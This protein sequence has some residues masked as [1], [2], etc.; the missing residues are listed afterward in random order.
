MPFTLLFDLDGTLLDTDPLHFQAYLG[1]LEAHAR[2]AIDFALYQTRIMGFGHAEI[3]AMLFPDCD[4]AR[5]AALADEKEQRFRTLLSDVPVDPRPGLVELL[6]WAGAHRIPCAV[7][8]NAPRENAMQI[9]DDPTYPESH[10][11]NAAGALY[12]LIPAKDKVL[13]PAGEWNKVRVLVRGNH[14]EHNPDT[15]G[16]QCAADE[17]RRFYP[18]NQRPAFATQ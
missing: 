18:R 9:L 11:Q 15:S 10:P 1:L 12:D 13:H 5:Y 2:P 14:V 16:G 7:V 4:P 17:R 3:F 8:T 6:D